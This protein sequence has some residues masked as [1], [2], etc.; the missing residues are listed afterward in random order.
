MSLSSALRGFGRFWLDFVVGDD[1]KIAAAVVLSLLVGVALTL[2]AATGA[3]W[4]APAIG[5]IVI[6]V[7]VVEMVIDVRGS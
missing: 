3:D 6:L 1:W 5:A 2:S 7:F 4:L